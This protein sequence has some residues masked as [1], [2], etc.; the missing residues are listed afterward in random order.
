MGHHRVNKLPTRQQKN[1][2]AVVDIMMKSVWESLDGIINFH[3]DDHEETSAHSDDRN[4]IG[5][6]VTDAIGEPVAPPQSEDEDE[7]D[8]DAVVP[9]DVIHRIHYRGHRRKP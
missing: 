5:F 2:D 1:M 6:H 9:L 7:D 4:R 3:D 8:D